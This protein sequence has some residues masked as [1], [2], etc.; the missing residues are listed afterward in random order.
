[1]LTGAGFALKALEENTG[2]ALESLGLFWSGICAPSPANAKVFVNKVNVPDLAVGHS[3]CFTNV[4]HI[5]GGDKIILMKFGR[6]VLP[7]FTEE[8]VDKESL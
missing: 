3:R 7:K 4:L 6:D 2:T 8:E 1:L 5:L